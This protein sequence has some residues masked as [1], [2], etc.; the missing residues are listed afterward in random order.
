MRQQLR[1]KIQWLCGGCGNRSALVTTCVLKSTTILSLLLLW[2][3]IC[4]AAAESAQI[5]TLTTA[6]YGAQ[7][8]QQTRENDWEFVPT[9]VTNLGGTDGY[10]FSTRELLE[11]SDKD[12]D[13]AKKLIDGTGNLPRYIYF[14]NSMQLKKVDSCFCCNCSVDVTFEDCDYLTYAESLLL[15]SGVILVIALF[16]LLFVATIT[17]C[18]R[19]FCGGCHPSKGTCCPDR[20]AW[21]AKYDGYKKKNL[22]IGQVV[23]IVFLACILPFTVL[24]LAGTIS[25]SSAI[26]NVETTFT[27]TAQD[28]LNSMLTVDAQF[29][30]LE[31]KGIYSFSSDV[32]PQL[33]Q[34][35]NKTTY[36]VD[37]LFDYDAQ[38]N[39]FDNIRNAVMF[40]I[41]LLPFLFGVA[42]LVGM[43]VMK[44]YLVAPLAISGLVF[45]GLALFATS[46]HYPISSGVGD[47]CTVIDE[48]LASGADNATGWATF[49]TDCNHSRV[50][51]IYN[52]T[53][54]GINDAYSDFCGAYDD[55]CTAQVPCDVN[56]D[57][58]YTPAEMCTPLNCSSYPPS[59]CA[60]PTSDEIDT[61]LNLP[62]VDITVGCVYNPSGLILPTD[63]PW[64]E[65]IRGTC[66]GVLVAC[67][68]YNDPVISLQNCSTECDYPDMQT[69]AT[70][71]TNALV[72]LDVFIQILHDDIEPL[73]N[74]EFLMG[75]F[76][77][78]KDEVCVMLSIAII[79]IIIS[80]AG[81]SVFLFPL[82]YMAIASIKRYNKKHVLGYDDG[83]SSSSDSSSSSS[84]S[85]SDSDSDD[86][87]SKKHNKHPDGGALAVPMVKIEHPE[88]P[89]D[90]EAPPPFF[91]VVV[92]A[93]DPVAPTVTL[94]PP[95]ADTAAHEGSS[96][97]SLQN[98]TADHH[99]S[100]SSSSS[101]ESH[102]SSVA[103]VL[104]TA[105]E[106]TPVMHD[107]NN[108]DS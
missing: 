81:S 78:T 15:S 71:M 28:I 25:F 12:R 102:E 5:T 6:P 74:C 105:D 56:G 99:S 30:D 46:L 57:G 3:C 9:T 108:G 34:V 69:A 45:S 11:V 16:I 27:G 79:Y 17:W 39:K 54:N 40:I 44:P 61:V 58:I 73:L 67:D 68:F 104:C 65:S 26:N 76:Y 47:S 1:T 36:Y 10:G 100:V 24:G 21:D 19:P 48:M 64:D 51:E 2:L 91:P 94:V 41:I 87:N 33:E 85:D 8:H 106:T 22:R 59:S 63:C 95:S 4:K 29:K 37:K 18:C 38:V 93:G 43:F 60:T 62:V 35:I 84:S 32:I 96:E 7:T 88:E 23:F 86:E 98:N 50:A 83:S 42:V 66:P 103:E 49:V 107:E 14:T 80:T 52:E 31:S 72:Q 13:R 70:N 90:E 89:N 97:V 53:Q 92:P 101:S 75:L 20:S 77:S 55:A 82:S